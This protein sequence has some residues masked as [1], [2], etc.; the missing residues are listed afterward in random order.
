MAKTNRHSNTAFRGFGG[1]QGMI[2]IEDILG[3][4]A[5]RSASSRTSYGT[6]T[7]TRPAR[8]RRTGSRCGTPSGS[9]RSGRS[10]TE[11]SEFARRQAEVAAFNAAHPDTKRGLAITPVKFG[12]SFNLTAFNQAGALVH[13]YKDGSVLINHGGTEMGQGLHTKMI[14]VAATALGVPMSTVRLA[15]TRTDKVPNTS[16]T[17]ASSG[18]DINGGAVKNA[19]DQIRE[20]L[21]IVAAGQLGVHPDDVRFCDGIVTGIGFGDRQLAWADLVHDAYYRRVQ[22]WAAGFYRTAGLHWDA[23]RMQGEP[24]KYFAYG[25]AAAEVEVDGFTGAYRLRRADIVHDVG[26]SLSPLIDLGQIEGGFVQG[27]GWLTLEEL[28]WDETDGPHRGRLNTQAASTY[29]IPSF[30]EMPPRVQRAPVRAGH[31]VRRGVRLQGGRRAAADGGVQRARGATAG[32]GRVRAGRLERGARLPVHPRGRLLGRPGGQGCCRPEDPAPA[33]GPG[34]R[35]GLTMDWLR[36]AQQLRDEGQPGVLVTV[37]EVRG[38]A[39]REAGAKMVVSRDRTW[40]S[41]GG[42]NLEATAVARARELIESGAAAPETSEAQLNP[43]A[44][45]E[46]GRQCCGGVVRLL[47][48]PLPVRPVI[49]LFGLGHVG[50]ELARILSRLPVRLLLVDSRPEQLDRVRLADVIDGAA[51][52][53]IYHT[54]LGEQV[55]EQLPRGAHVVIMTHDH[56]EDFALCDAALRLPQPLGGIGLIG[57]SAKWTR[58]AAQLAAAGHAPEAI[59]RI[60]CP[61]GQPGITGKDPAIIA[62]A[63]AAALLAVLPASQRA[64]APTGLTSDGGATREGVASRAPGGEWGKQ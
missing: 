34:S 50:Y 19:C 59:A 7:S 6:G 11:R 31:R 28:L 58:F 56:A 21:A 38:H 35:G 25:A 49:A 23:E 13:V 42:G 33:A 3:R 40:G 47:L 54:M 18:S 16:A 61:I 55:L 32:G 57:S 24:F 37:A 45:N 5:P 48:E 43:H 64:P 12:I 51:D 46:H 30:S 27:V 14:Q 39:P 15:P 17:A 63:V 44:R 52:V 22:L 26:D 62:V 20:R 29:K 9:R 10:C 4:C 8:P 60:T 1:P 53:G 2:V 36:A 41:V